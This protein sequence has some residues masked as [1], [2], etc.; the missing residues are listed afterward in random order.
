MK[1]T[2]DDDR[3]RGHGV[4]L[5]LCPEVFELTDYGYAEVTVTD[6]PEQYEQAVRDAEQA[7]P[8]RAIV[9]E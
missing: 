9:I 6:V 3:C 2:I 1:V 4:C 8:E 5:G 7:C